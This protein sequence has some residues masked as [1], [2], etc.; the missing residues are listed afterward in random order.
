MIIALCVLV[1]LG[2][3]VLAQG[4]FRHILSIEGHSGGKYETDEVFRPFLYLMLLV[5][6]SIGLFAAI[7]VSWI[8]KTWGLKYR[9]NK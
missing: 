4:I 3:G 1:W 2:C 9:N 6:G 8:N 5:L 7:I